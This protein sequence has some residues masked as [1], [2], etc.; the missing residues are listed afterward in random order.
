ME[1]SEE[2]EEADKENERSALLKTLLEKTKMMNA[3]ELDEETT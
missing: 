2:A 1:R 3:E